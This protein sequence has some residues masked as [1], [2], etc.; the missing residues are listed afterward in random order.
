M[1]IV[2]TNVKP[3]QPLVALRKLAN[4]DPL[5]AFRQAIVMNRAFSRYCAHCARVRG[6]DWADA[7]C[8]TCSEWRS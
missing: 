7:Q 1:M 5:L 3:A 6:T 4:T 2:H 8:S